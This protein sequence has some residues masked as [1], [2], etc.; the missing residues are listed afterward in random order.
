M[1]AALEATEESDISKLQGVSFSSKDIHGFF[2]DFSN[3]DSSEKLYNHLGTLLGC[4]MTIQDILDQRKN[5][6]QITSADITSAFRYDSI[7][8]KIIRDL[9]VA[10]EH[11]WH[12]THHG[13]TK[14]RKS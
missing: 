9:R 13:P 8:L 7:A 10:N 4:I 11:G 1:Y 12:L 2:N 3:G 6:Y 14:N 5:E